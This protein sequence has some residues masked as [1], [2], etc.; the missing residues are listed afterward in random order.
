MPY[1]EHIGP[2][3]EFSRR[4]HFARFREKISRFLSGRG[5][6]AINPRL[7]EE[8]AFTLNHPY[9]DEYYRVHHEHY[10]TP[11]VFLEGTLMPK[12]PG[13]VTVVVTHPD[14]K[15]RPGFDYFVSIAYPAP[16]GELELYRDFAALKQVFDNDAKQISFKIV[17]ETERIEEYFRSTIELQAGSE[18]YIL[19]STTLE[20]MIEHLE[21]E[22]IVRPEDGTYVM[23][24]QMKLDQILRAI[25]YPY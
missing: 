13:D 5:G 24:M 21:P 15:S 6:D 10:L 7:V 1:P 4:E 8:Q 23:S 3:P 25:S 19:E 18:V 14:A 11:R 20:E 22:D 2:D 12:K 16:E 9:K 17:D